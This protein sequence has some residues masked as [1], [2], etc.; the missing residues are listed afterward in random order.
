MADPI[1]IFISYKTGETT[2]LTFQARSIKKELSQRKGANY[3]VWFDKDSLEAGLDWNSQIYKNIPASDILLLLLAKETAESDWVR[4]E[5]DVAKGAQVTILP[6]LIRDFDDLQGAL[7]RFDIPRLQ[8]VTLY[9]GSDDEFEKLFAAIEQRKA[10]THEAQKQFLAKL[11]RGPQSHPVEKPNRNYWVYEV[12]PSE[13]SASEGEG[14][15][16]P[17]VHLAAGDIMAMKPIDVFVN[18]END[19]MQMARV[20]DN[21]TISSMLRFRGSHFDGAKRLLDDTLQNEL[22][23]QV[24]KYHKTRPLGMGA[25][26]A[27]RAG[28]PESNL[29]KQNGARFVFHTAVVSVRDDDRG[30]DPRPDQRSDFDGGGPRNPSHG[31]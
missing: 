10:D 18:S 30:G 11:G 13:A 16:G 3:H 12:N 1:Q 2:G 17:K 22:T 27:T 9:E 7:D 31:E 25:V 26:V 14:S 29:V 15:G 23:E 19:Y 20:F 6:V 21:R 28:H 24:K 4:R 5:I 8:A